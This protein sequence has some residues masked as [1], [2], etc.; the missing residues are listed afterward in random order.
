V[1][2]EEE[3]PDATLPDK[4]D[5]EVPGEAKNPHLIG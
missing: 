5:A 4:V 1:D 3:E 2:D